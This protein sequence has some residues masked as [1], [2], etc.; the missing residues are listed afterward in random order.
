MK[1]NKI[2][3]ILLHIV[4]QTTCS[5]STNKNEKKNQEQMLSSQLIQT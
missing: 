1:M 4:N 5:E 3:Y 2:R